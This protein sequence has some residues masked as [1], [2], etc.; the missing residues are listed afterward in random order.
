[1]RKSTKNKVAK[2]PIEKPKADVNAVEK[3]TEKKM[4][5]PSVKQTVEKPVRVSPVIDKCLKLYS[6]IPELYVSEDG[7]VYVKGTPT[8]MRGK[9]KLYKNKYYKKQ[10]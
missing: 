4:A 9:A 7:F 3:V 5:A 1:M 10:G 8:S 6:N 2:P